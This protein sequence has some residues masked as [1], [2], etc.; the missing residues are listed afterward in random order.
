MLEQRHAKLNRISRL[1]RWCLERWVLLFCLLFALMNLLPF[2]APIFMQLGWTVPARVIYIIYSPLCHQMAQRSFFLFGEQAMYNIAEL[3][4][5]ISGNT[6]SDMVAL[7]SFIG[8]PD[9]GWKVAW[10]D[11]MVYMYGAVLLVS[12][13]YV[14]LRHR[15]P[16]R[17]LGL[18]F[19]TLLL[20]PLV[21]D[22]TSHMLS[23]M[24]YGLVEGFRYSNLW[25]A[26]LTGHALPSWFYR[27]D[28]LGSFNSW[29][30][31]ISGLGFG[32]A[33]VWFAFPYL[34]RPISL[35]LAVL[36]SKTSQVQNRSP[37]QTFDEG[38]TS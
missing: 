33:C 5:P 27:G 24:N 3:P 20:I 7:R 32:F 18:F 28:A 25:L 26:D 38:S 4:V 13:A 19:A 10:S 29:M 9:M 35:T 1:L 31:L 15:R 16:I 12:I 37:M 36:S 8:N 11:R 14:L 6:V 22:G 21:V 17:P 34:D 30:R 23:D 2:M